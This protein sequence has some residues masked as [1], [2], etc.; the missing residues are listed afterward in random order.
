MK[1]GRKEEGKQE[2]RRG[3]EK[4]LYELGR[5]INQEEGCWQEWKEMRGWSK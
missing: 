1:K 3:E 5:G 4:K 2:R